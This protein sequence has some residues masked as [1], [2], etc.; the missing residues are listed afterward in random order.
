MLPQYSHLRCRDQGLL[1]SAQANPQPHHHRYPAR[2]D[3]LRWGQGNAT[4]TGQQRV[5][6]DSTPTVTYRRVLWRDLSCTL[7]PGYAK[8]NEPYGVFF[9]EIP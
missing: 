5:L 2:V 3:V 6:H 7:V 1:A 8:E 9:L 4:G